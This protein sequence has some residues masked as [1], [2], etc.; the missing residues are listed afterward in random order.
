MPQ[1]NAD[2]QYSVPLPGVTPDG[3]VESGINENTGKENTVPV[4]PLYRWYNIWA[5]EIGAEWMMDGTNARMREIQLGYTLPSA[6]VS[7]T[8]L[9]DITISVVSHHTVFLYNA[10]KDIDP[11]SSYSSGNTG[12]GFEHNSIPST[13]SFRF[14]LKFHFLITKYNHDKMITAMDKSV[15]KT[16]PQSFH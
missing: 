15:I 16:V 13:R 4:D 9:D 12:G 14:D 10:M 2:Y 5:K 8:P 1:L 11:E 3:Y 6:F 7:K